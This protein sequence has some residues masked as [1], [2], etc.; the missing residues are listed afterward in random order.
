MWKPG[1]IF[2]KE[3]TPVP[4]PP[5]TFILSHDALPDLPYNAQF[6]IYKQNKAKT[7]HHSCVCFLFHGER[8]LGSSSS[9]SLDCI[10]KGLQ[11]NQRQ[12]PWK[13]GFAGTYL[14]SCVVTLSHPVVCACLLSVDIELRS[15]NQKGQ[16][17]FSRCSSE[18]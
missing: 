11:Q 3:P 8:E 6:P 4:T 5:P 17:L 2:S 10:P 12:G 14:P 18:R 16:F 7:P 13:E 15:G 1:A 9:S